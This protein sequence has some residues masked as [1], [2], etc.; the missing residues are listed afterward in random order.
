MAVGVEVQLFLISRVGALGT[1]IT[2]T[3]APLPAAL[4]VPFPIAF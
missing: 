3:R 2:L 4:I 1:T